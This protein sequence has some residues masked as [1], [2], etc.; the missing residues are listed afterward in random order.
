MLTAAELIAFVPTENLE[1]SVAFYVDRLGFELLESSEHAA[2]IN[3]NGTNVRITPV[4]ARAD[5]QYTVLG[6][7]VTDIRETARDLAARGVSFERYDGLE[8]DD[9]GIWPAP[10]GDQVA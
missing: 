7:K 5:A 9:L 1:Q 10:G 3:A 4:P 2:V 8:Q 6:W